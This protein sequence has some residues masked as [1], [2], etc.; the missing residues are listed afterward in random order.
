MPGAGSECRTELCH[1]AAHRPGDSRR[2]NLSDFTY[3]SIWQGWLC[4]AFVIDVFAR[5]IMGWRVSRTM[6]T[7]VV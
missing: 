1:P 4:V 3:V 5:R 6:R 7:D 2:R